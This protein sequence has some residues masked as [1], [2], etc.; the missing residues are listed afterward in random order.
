M[1]DLV[2]NLIDSI[3]YIGI[4]IAMFLKNAFLPFPSEVVMV[5]SGATAA[6]G[7]L[8][9]YLVILSGITGSLLG[10]VPWYFAAKRYGLE[11][12]RHFTDTHSR[13]LTFTGKDID[14]AHT[15]FNKH[16]IKVIF[17]GRF[18]PIIRTLLAIPAAITNMDIKKFI[19]F[20][21][22]GS[23]VWD[24][25]FAWIGYALGNNIETVKVY[26]NIATYIIFGGIVFGYLY[27]I[28]HAKPKS[29]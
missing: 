3:G 22:L 14:K 20:A 16:G 5:F 21:L 19:F 2:I 24:G 27:R 18:V 13:W 4:I 7:H 28:F 9:I 17:F 8:N 23:L 26:V 29:K 15:W 10:L 6:Q 11:K 1:F 12:V 25:V